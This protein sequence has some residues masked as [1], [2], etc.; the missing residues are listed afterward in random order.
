[1]YVSSSFLLLIFITAVLSNIGCYYV[2]KIWFRPRSSLLY[3]L[4]LYSSQFIE[5]QE[6]KK[7]TS[8]DDDNI[9]QS[10][11]EELKEEEED[12]DVSSST[13]SNSLS[14]SLKNKISLKAYSLN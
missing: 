4:L 8:N 11:I 1:M 14:K 12:S 5:E 6:D 7:S 9:Q 13:L 2:G 10:Q 3:P